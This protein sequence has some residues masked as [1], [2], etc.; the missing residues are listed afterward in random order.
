VSVFAVREPHKDEPPMT[1][2]EVDK[3]LRRVTLT[4]AS[5]IQPR[6]VHWLWADRVPLGSLTLLAGREGIGKS[7]V[8]YTLAGDVSR[9]RLPGRYAGQPRAVLVAA[10]EDSWEH[11]IVPRLMAAD[12]DLDRVFRIDVET[13]SGIGTGLSL[14]RD[15]VQVERHVEDNRAGL[16][17]LDPLMSR[18]DGKLDT[19]KDAEV[20]LAL[21]PL[22]ALADRSGAAVVG[23][24]HVNKGSSTDPLTLIMGSRAFAAVA[25]AVLFVMTDPDDDS[26]RLLGQEKNNLG[27]TDL[28]TLSFRID[29]A[30]VVDD[31]L[32]P[33]TTGRVH[34]LGESIRTIREALDS[35]DRETRSATTE[36]ADWLGDYLTSK[37]GTE[38]SADI[39]REGL[40]AGHSADSLK[41][42]RRALQLEISASG[43]PRHT[44]WTLPGSGPQWEQDSGS[45]PGES[46]LTTPTTPTG[47]VGAVGAVGADPA[48]DAPTDDQGAR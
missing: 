25:R 36:A 21:E 40:K 17:L 33:V 32:D 47:A 14:P 44:F 18:L 5:S 20:R 26:L 9:G 23:L 4:A 6:P 45:S 11:T 37:G 41:R 28:P 38:D 42:A 29:T 35:G 31:P 43:W 48:R 30:T 34:W 12:A 13:S 8:G 7:T 2:Q 16:I 22:T 10:T 1:E 39:K 15:L 3:H 19:H 46:A 24:I 27:R